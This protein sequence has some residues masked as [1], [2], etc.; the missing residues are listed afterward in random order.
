MA[1]LQQTGHFLE[2]LRLHVEP[3]VIVFRLFLG[4]LSLSPVGE[5]SEKSNA[6]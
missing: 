6:S 4:S 5:G 2:Y 3:I 1:D